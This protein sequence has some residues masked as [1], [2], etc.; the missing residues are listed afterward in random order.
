MP[1]HTPVFEDPKRLL[2]DLAQQRDLPS[3]LDLLVTR[4]GDSDTVALVR[5]WLLRPGD[6]CDACLFREECP[7]RSRC[8][9]L[10]ASS[11]RSVVDP[12]RDLSRLDGRFRRFPVGV[13]KVGRIAMTGDPIEAPDLADMPD[14]IADPEWVRSEGVIGFAGQPLS[15]H[16]MVLG[17]LGVFSRVR[18]SDE[19]LDWMRM[20][21]DHAAA[22][23]AHSHAWDELQLLRRRL[24]EENEYLQQ[25]VT[26][27]QGFGEMLGTSPAL[28]NVGRQIELVAKTDSTVLILGESGAGKELVARELHRH[29]ARAGRPLIKVNCAAVPRELFESE[30]FGHAKGA[31]TGALRDRVGRFELADGGTLFLDEVGEVPID[32]QSKLLRVLQE[33]EI[34]RVGEEQ[35]RR[36]D[37][38][39][40]AATN[41]DLRDESRRGR[42]RED[43]FYRL[44]VFP[45]ELPPL[46]DRRE[47]IPLL[48]EHFLAASARRIGVA[49]PRLTKALARQLAQYDWPGNIRELQHVIERA[50]IL[51]QGGPLR[52]SLGEPSGANASP[53]VAAA[54]EV[55]TDQQFREMEKQN[56]QRALAATR[57]K[58][59]GP[60]GAA[61]LLGVRPTTLNSR[62][63]AMGVKKPPAD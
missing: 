50:V 59:Y 20:I 37:V 19:C 22:S 24:E 61:E 1:A 52:V 44:S 49:A 13:R 54:P 11:G 47:D 39:V 45:I 16:G 43:L 55:L 27:E 3:L 31:F 12:D 7:D 36:V 8:L 2:L 25:E 63:A 34:E 60:G 32:L 26:V 46:R 23:I 17:V 38:R 18:I 9:H 48:A 33:G 51:C 56:L 10:A 62:L 4:I 53:P 14:W 29:S 35:T 40:I 28:R 5:V 21:A 42:F 15:H 6:I 41:R 57:G 30:F 58:V